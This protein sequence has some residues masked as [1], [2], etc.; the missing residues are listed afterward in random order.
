MSGSRYLLDTNAVI[1]LLQ[2]NDKVIEILKPA[3]WI[4]IS[5]I[6]QIEFL[7]FPDMTAQGNILF[8]NFLKKVS[9]AELAGN[10]TEL[11]EYIVDIR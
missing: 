11:I 2:G 7:V 9:V 5:I 10:Q 8:D 1:A 3:E 6:T 4:G